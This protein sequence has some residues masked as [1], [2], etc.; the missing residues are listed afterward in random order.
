MRALRQSA[1]DSAVWS[2]LA[3]ALQ[4]A[5]DVLGWGRTTVQ[6]LIAVQ[7]DDSS[8]TARIARI[9]DG[10]RLI[11]GAE[12]FFDWVPGAWRRSRTA[13]ALEEAWNAFAALELWQRLRLGGCA[14]LAAVPTAATISWLARTPTN[15]AE[16][17]L[18][19]VVL[20][21]AI[22]LAAASRPLADAWRERAAR[23][24]KR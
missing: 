12:R 17:G 24:R 8:E 14:L 3:R 18:S 22:A 20:L 19:I 16:G 4:A 2:V 5:D 11:R 21:V 15:R 6:S 10:S 23:V 9:A 1:N 13:G 7:W